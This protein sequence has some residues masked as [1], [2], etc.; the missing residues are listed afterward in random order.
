MSDMF[1]RLK[2]ALAERYALERELGRGGMATVYLAEDLK[3]R[4]KVAVKVLSPEIANA[5]G[6]DRFLR[7]IEI[8]AG[9]QHPHILPLYDS[10]EADDLLYYVMPYVEGEPLS[11]R[12][13]REGALPVEEA[14]RILRDVA[15]ALAYAHERGVIHRDIKP[16]NVM[17]S[18]NHAVVTDFGVAKAVSEAAGSQTLTSTGVAL[19]TPAYMAPEQATADPHVDHRADIYAVGVVGYEVLAGRAPFDGPTAQAVLA[20]HVTEVPEPVAKRRRGIPAGLSA[21][22]MR[23]LEKLPADRIQ[24]TQELLHLLEALATPTG[25]AAVSA[26]LTVPPITA[27]LARVAALYGAASVVTAGLVYSLMLVL[28]LP[29]WVLPGGLLL[30]AVGLPIIL[31]TWR[32]ERD[33]AIDRLDRETGSGAGLSRLLTWRKAIAGGGLAFGALGL[34]TA[35]YMAMRLLG[36]GPVGTLV[37]AGVLEERD[38]IVLADFVDRTGDSTLAAAVTE[39]FR[40]DLG[41]SPT[42]TLV[43]TAELL[44]AFARM[45][46]QPPAV[47]TSELAREVAAREGIKAVVSGEINSL[48]GSYVLSAQLLEAG[49]GDVLV[50]LRETAKDSTQLID[51]LDRLSKR[52]RERVGE[53]LNSIREAPALERVSTASL[54][55]LRKHSQAMRAVEAGDAGRAIALFREAI[56]LDTTFAAAYRGLSVQLSNYGIDRALAV[57]SMSKAYEYRDR[58]TERERLWTIGSYHMRRLEI[59]EALTP[60]LALFELEPNDPKLSNNLGVL[61]NLE[62][63][64]ERSLE[65]YLQAYELMPTAPSVNFNIVVTNIELGRLD[66]ARAANERFVEAVP[67]HPIHQVNNFFIAGAEFDY[68]TAR[69]SI[70]AWAAYGDLA[71]ESLVTSTLGGL[72]AVEGKIAELERRLRESETRAASGRQVREHLLDA[73]YV[74]LFD[75]ETRGRPEQGIE[76]VQRALEAFPLESLEPFDRPYAELAEFYARLGRVERASEMLDAFDR[77]VSEEFAPMADIEYQR[78][79]GYHALAQ[80]RYD[81]AMVRFLASDRGSCP[82]CVLPGLARLHDQTGNT[83]S[84][85][86]V[87]ER[88]LTTPDDDRLHV[89]FLELPGV[90]VRL[91]ELYEARGERE[92]A[93]ENYDRFVDLWQGADAELQL[94]VDDVRRRI[95]RLAAETSSPD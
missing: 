60:Y 71:S 2:Q 89:D 95:A 88:Y 44:D 56:T 78:A 51:A 3:H 40:V 38:R 18:G 72:A 70:E 10:G 74:G 84:L 80:K 85:I 36:I 30:L 53:S 57:E 14:V 4:R 22:V 12:L 37:A 9:L 47:M 49:S 77:E 58:L 25:T 75:A 17:L 6:G 82:V 31:M 23:C 63:D 90:Y 79:R 46:R 65:Y 94:Q 62:G 76:R 39:A 27:R 11:A 73:V 13:A 87:L 67:N 61:Y 8:A 41:Q 48:G 52:L 21:L 81:E 35:A 5:L 54:P 7:E 86:T 55:A 1:E 43:Q 68:A 83:D 91:G 92:Q 32:T 15:D 64:N 28:G 20:A 69:E 16:D 59:Q 19:G 33:R 50:P 42:V 34:L 29:D 24:R 93:I 45:E 66:D 26:Q